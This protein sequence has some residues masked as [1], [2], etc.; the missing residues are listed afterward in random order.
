MAGGLC[1]MLLGTGIMMA[2]RLPV[3]PLGLGLLT[4]GLFAAHGC[5]SAAASITAD[6]A[7]AQAALLYLFAFY[8]GW[9]VIG[10][11]GGHVWIWGCWPAVSAY[12]IVLGPAGLTIAAA[13]ASGRRADKAAL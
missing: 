1:L 13:L 4:A 10:W 8:G 7:K 6:R 5:A 3:V 2:D 11:I 9:G 12:L